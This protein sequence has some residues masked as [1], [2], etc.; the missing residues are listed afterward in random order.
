[1]N[2]DTNSEDRVYFIGQEAETT[3]PER[4]RRWHVNWT[5][6][7]IACVIIAGLAY[8]FYTSREVSTS[9]FDVVEVVPKD[10]V[11]PKFNGN[12]DITGFLMWIGNNLEYPEGFETEDA[13][14]VVS[15]VV[16]KTGKVSDIIIES[17]PKEKAFGRKVVALLESSPKWTPA[18]LA[19]GTSVGVRYTLPVD[20]TESE[21]NSRREI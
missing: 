5:V 17:E 19:D 15:F 8:L 14:V 2:K 4:K 11:A 3:A 6:A 21:N 1:M 10:A 18:K 20:S 13:Y 7:A 12:E 16:S 9:Q